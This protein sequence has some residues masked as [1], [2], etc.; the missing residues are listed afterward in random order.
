[1]TYTTLLTERTG[2]IWHGH[3]AGIKP[4]QLYGYRVHGPYEPERGLR[5]NPH[6]L[7]LD[8]YA[9]AIGRDLRWNDALFGYAIG[10]PDADLSCDLRDSAP[11]APV[12]AVVDPAFTCG[13]DRPPLSIGFFFS[14]GH[15]SVVFALA[16][17]L[18]V[19]AAWTSGHVGGW[20]Q[21]GR[22][23]AG[24][25]SG[26]LLL[27]VAVMNVIS[28]I[29]VVR[30]ESDLPATPTARGPITRL[31]A[32]P[33]SMVRHSWHAYP[34]GMLF[35]LGLDTASEVILLALNAGAASGDLPAPAVLA[36]PLLFAAG[37]S[38]FDTADGILMSR[39]YGWGLGRPGRRVLYNAAITAFSIVAA[40]SIGIVQLLDPGVN[41]E[42]TG[43]ALA[44]AFLA[45]WVIGVATWHLTHMEQ[46]WEVRR[47]VA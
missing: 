32:R 12:A 46:R 42:V 35:G 18:A 9:K 40:L 37:M 47:G 16:A 17:S 29:A 11:C 4:G 28:L 3:L 31:L 5:F 27:L 1:M 2:G 23:L 7:L 36:L 13:D 19:A 6:K 20:A 8:P 43:Y 39:A 38:A 41:L 22:A 21:S 30:S 14:L 24:A 25:L 44:G 26:G 45:M 10:G 34:L 33:L 15:A